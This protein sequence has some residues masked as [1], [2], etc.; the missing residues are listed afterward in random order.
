MFVIK[1]KI[2]YFVTNSYFLKTLN[3]YSSLSLN[4][5]YAYYTFLNSTLLNKNDIFLVK[6]QIKCVQS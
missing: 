4:I 6:L 5:F 2:I 3:L 1:H